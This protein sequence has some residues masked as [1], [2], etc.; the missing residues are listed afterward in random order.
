MT[1][2]AIVLLLCTS[3]AR[4][5]Y[6]TGKGVLP[7]LEGTAKTKILNSRYLGKFGFDSGSGW[8]GTSFRIVPDRQCNATATMDDNF[9]H[10]DVY[11]G[12]D[13]YHQA[14][15][16]GACFNEDKYW[17]TT[18]DLI[19]GWKIGKWSPWSNTSVGIKDGKPRV[20]YFSMSDCNQTLPRP[21]QNQIE[22]KLHAHQPDG[23]EVGIDHPAE[24]IADLLTLAGA[25]A[26][27]MFMLSKRWIFKGF[28]QTPWAIKMLG[29]SVIFRLAESIV[30]TL[31]LWHYME[32]GQDAMMTWVFVNLMKACGALT[33]TTL[34][35]SVVCGYTLVDPEGG[36]EFHMIPALVLIGHFFG[37]GMPFIWLRFLLAFLREEYQYEFHELQGSYGWA[38]F[39][40]DAVYNLI[41]IGIACHAATRARK[42]N[43]KSFQYTL[44]AYGTLSIGSF[45]MSFLVSKT[46]PAHLQY[47]A[48]MVFERGIQAL[49][50][51]ALAGVFLS[52]SGFLKVCAHV[53][54]LP[55]G[56][57]SEWQNREGSPLV[58]GGGAAKA[59]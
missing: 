8:L 43:A 25:A 35:F 44:G 22:F 45:W 40:I 1:A 58:G 38:L 33:M 7:H 11:D 52:P 23:R 55:H 13:S 26:T 19:G 59:E 15:K 56:D 47:S 3:L 37:P 30:M 27:F 21:C 48:Y 14:M 24:P 28:A 34:L 10:L 12:L 4:G 6:L 39:A 31:G 36:A 2:R 57:S 49:S 18:V 5:R 9:I 54:D 17:T 42:D 53:T 50:Q 46:F 41:F 32:Y 51:F 20:L 29:L 16:Q